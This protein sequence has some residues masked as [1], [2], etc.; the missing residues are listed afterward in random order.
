[1]KSRPLAIT[2]FSLTLLAVGLSVPAQAAYLESFDNFFR[3]LTVLNAVMAALCVLTAAAVFTVHN[4][5]RV[6]LP[7][8][9]ATVVFNN[10]WVGY[11]GFDFSMMQTTAAS[12]GF[13]ALCCSLLEKNAFSVLRN[14]KLKWWNVAARKKVS[15]PVTLKKLRGKALDIRAFD[16][17]ESGIFLQ[18]VDKDEF[19]NYEI[20]ERIEVDLHF[21]EILKVRC[22]AR[23]VRKTHRQGMYPAGMGLQFT[24]K[25]RETK[26]TLQ[27][28]VR[29]VEASA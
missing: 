8:T 3:S 9:F 19:R 4:S 24:E 16:I 29:E 6:L 1:M 2:I 5:L 18:D 21:N 17:S 10:W 14:P 28:L 15:I 23:V 13:A 11:V 12:F 7:L 26:S 27:R 22:E 20:G 25:N